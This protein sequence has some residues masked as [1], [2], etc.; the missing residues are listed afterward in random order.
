LRA[1]TRPDPGGTWAIIPVRGLERGKSRLAGPLD[2]EER[3]D[4]VSRLLRRAIEAATSS[5]TVAGTIVV[6]SDP[7]ALDLAGAAGAIPVVDH[8]RGLNPA[9]EQARVEA[10][11]RGAT[12]LVIL[13]ADLP[14]LDRDSL[15]SVLVAAGEAAGTR[16]FVGLVTDRHGTGTNVLIL[17]PPGV[18]AFAFGAGSRS[19]HAAAAAAVGATYAELGGPLD[20]DLDTP[21][22]LVL[23]EGLDPET[24]DVG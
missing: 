7:A 13:P 14:W 10:L 3:L 17:T 8:D 18:I 19:V 11:A 1:T 22:D 5:I 12:T 15:E 2:A 23:I 9:L 16:P 20:V 24:I 6:S 4:L 21:E